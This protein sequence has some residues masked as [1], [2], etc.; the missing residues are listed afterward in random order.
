M[1]E[2]EEKIARL[3]MFLMEAERKASDVY[4]PILAQI[5]EIVGKEK[6]TRETGWRLREDD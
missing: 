6:P 4:A 2:A 5:W 1:T 3:R